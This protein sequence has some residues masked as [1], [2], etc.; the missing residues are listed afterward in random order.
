[1]ANPLLVAALKQAAFAGMCYLA[2]TT[3]FLRSALRRLFNDTPAQ[4]ACKA[5]DLIY[6]VCGV[7][8][9]IC[10]DPVPPFTGGQCAFPYRV[11]T[12]IQIN[13]ANI[14]ATDIL[15]EAENIVLGPIQGAFVRSHWDGVRMLWQVGVI[16][17]VTELQPDAYIVQRQYFQSLYETPT[18]EFVFVEPADGGPDTCGDPEPQYPYYAP[19]SNKYET[20][21]TYDTPSGDTF[22]I[23]VS[24]NFGYFKLDANLNLTIPFTANLNNTFKIDGTINLNGGDINFN[25]PFSPDGSDR[26][27]LP[28]GPPTSPPDPDTP[29]PPPPNP[30]GEP[31]PPPPDEPDKPGLSKRIVGVHVTVNEVGS[32]S[33]LTEVFQEGGNPNFFLPDLGTVSFYCPSSGR[34]AAWTE[35]TKV[36][37]RVQLIPCPWKY[38]AIAVAGSE[39]LGVSWTLTPIYEQVEE[40]NNVLV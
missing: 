2:G 25:F 12:R 20:D 32:G 27:P 34:S 19:G 29:D 8:P 36:Q 18:V 15:E 38:G 30:P 17:A 3:P 31:P 4:S 40:N 23:P 11:R 16:G 6:L 9:G 39:R 24:F 35:P 22:T 7:S 33:G 37:Y 21:I 10:P 1:M 14:F 28:P 26:P 5:N 13:A